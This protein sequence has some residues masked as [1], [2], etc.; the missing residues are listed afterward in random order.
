MI[1]LEFT[2]EQI[3][4]IKAS[5]NHSIKSPDTDETGILVLASIIANINQQMSMQIDEEL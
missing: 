5:L 3:N 2:E 1:V 4:N